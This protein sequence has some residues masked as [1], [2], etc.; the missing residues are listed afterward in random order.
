MKRFF[1]FTVLIT[2]MAL[3]NATII[4][5]QKADT[6]YG[7]TLVHD[8]YPSWSPDGKKIVFQSNRLDG[9]FELYSMNADGNNIER[10]TFNTKED[11]TPVWSPSGKE[12]LFSRYLEGENNELF[13]IAPNGSK[14]KRLTNHPLRDGHAKYNADGSKIIFNSQRDDEG[15][16]ELKNYEI[17]EANSEG[18]LIKRLTNYFEWDTY[19][20][21]SPD[22]KKILWRRIL[23]DTT[24]PR[25][26]N[27]EIFLMNADGSELRNLSNHPSFDGY[28]EWSSDGEHIVFASSRHG[29]T[30]QNLQ[31]FIMKNDGTD[32]RQISWNN[33]DEEDVRPDWS[34]V[35][36]RV[37]FNRV[38]PNGTRIH[39]LRINETESRFF[40]D[41]EKQTILNEGHTASRGLAWGDLD[42]DGYS[43][44]VIA[45]T[46]N[47]S[48]YLYL[49]RAL[50]DF[51]QLTEG[52]ETTSAG[53]TE[54]VN[55]IDYDNDGDLDIFYTT[56][57]GEPNK[58]F[59]N[60]GKAVFK[61]A[62]AGDLT[63][64][65]SN[66]TTACW[67]DY[68]L[69]G[70]LDVYV[71]ERD[72]NIDT[73]FEN[74]GNGAFSAIVPSRFP[75]KAGDG[76]SCAWADTNGDGFPELYVGN[77]LDLAEEGERK[78]AR[79][80]YYL[81]LGEG[82]F[83]FEEGQVITS[84]RNLTYGVSFIDFD[85]DDDLDLFITNIAR[86]DHNRL[87]ANDGKGNFTEVNSA[88]DSV[89]GKPSKGHTWGDFDNDTDLDLFIA[90][91]TEGTSPE[92]VENDFFMQE[93]PG[94]FKKVGSGS[95]TST[96]RI[97]AGTAW[98]DYDRDGD[99]DLFLSNWGSNTAPNQFYRNNVYGS[100][101]LE[102]RLKGKSENRFGIG[103]K[104]RILITL[105][106]EKKWLSRWLWPQTG[107]ASQNEPLLHFGLATASLVEELII[108]WPSGK[109]QTLENIKANQFI[110]IEEN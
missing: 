77:F 109:T 51:K 104:V 101:W 10:L 65:K 88:I 41:E 14:E 44:L 71:I 91:G 2:C 106:G 32:I 59:Q 108:S 46:M 49:G 7:I 102:I 31:L 61:L 12:I 90:N 62:E 9:N 69:D 23:A 73:L 76:R 98:A 28:P 74:L 11:E 1:L 58:L 67:C 96:S 27:S 64:K 105:K 78:K 52:P 16:L 83:T 33:R 42:Q 94:E 15:K 6:L 75:Y 26:Y 79:N 70:D 25:G 21:Y 100:N 13:T 82:N 37:V 80:F 17:Y 89:A 34:P 45:N 3:L 86:S 53:W 87:Y 4:W 36:N 54:G 43:D 39:I 22:G 38:T 40:F 47:N 63:K 30:T 35:D 50:P 110:T 48:N 81:N 29:K 92:M 57:L 8:E 60:N 99:L 68:D 103:A 5:A 19:P 66:S 93:A 85:Q 20:S 107:Y 72:G 95:A 24:A 84:E 97:S 56:Q 55:L 18:S